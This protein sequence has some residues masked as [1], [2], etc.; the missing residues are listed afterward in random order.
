MAR[1]KN[2]FAM[3]FSRGKKNRRKS[4][5]RRA[6]QEIPEKE[7]EKEQ[8]DPAIPLRYPLFDPR[9]VKTRNEDLGDAPLSRP[10]SIP[11]EMATREHIELPVDD[12]DRFSPRS[13]PEN[14]ETPSLPVE[15]AQEHEPSP[16]ASLPPEPRGDRSPAVSKPPS[17][18]PTTATPQSPAA[19]ETPAPQP[20]APPP[21]PPRAATPPQEPEEV[22]TP[23]PPPP[24]PLRS[25]PPRE[26]PGVQLPTPQPRSFPP[27]EPQES[28]ASTERETSVFAPPVPVEEPQM[29]PF[30]KL[31]SA[32]ECALSDSVPTAPHTPRGSPADDMARRIQAKLAELEKMQLDEVTYYHKKKRRRRLCRMRPKWRCVEQ[33]I[34]C[35]ADAHES[36]TEYCREKMKV[37]ERKD[38]TIC[39]VFDFSDVPLL[40]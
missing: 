9:A 26:E 18:Q 32:R 31:E 29:S 4:A 21:S 30:E 3:C 36:F 40:Q 5:E 28:K 17:R 35:Y 7:G 27:T 19:E 37:H 24:S 6:A 23:Q 34:D 8:D 13:S 12:E 1:M 22:K 2:P 33:A 25:A 15:P 10:A 14:E 38:C 11:R 39:R 16:A 20:V